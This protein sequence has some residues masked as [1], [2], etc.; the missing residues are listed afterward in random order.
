MRRFGKTVWFRWTAPA[1]GDAV[2]AANST[3]P[4]TVLA[5]YPAGSTNAI[6]CS[7]D[8]PNSGTSS[9]LPVRVQGGQTYDIQ[10]GGYGAGQSADFGS[11]NLAVEFTP[12]N[13]ADGDGSSP[14]ADC[15]DNNA[16]IHPGAPD[17]RNGVDDDCDGVIDPD[18]DGDGYTRPSDCNDDNPRIHPGATDIRGNRV[19]EDCAGKPAPFR[20]IKA[21]LDPAGGH[22]GSLTILTSL[23][24][25]N[26]PKG[27]KVNLRCYGPGA[28][29]RPTCGTQARRAAA[30]AGVVG[31]A[32]R[33][34]PLRGFRR[35]LAP[36]SVIEVRATKRGYI[37]FFQKVTMRASGAP[38]RS[39]PKCT[40][41][42]S[43]KLRTKCSGTR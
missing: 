7:D 16:S 19:N 43:R 15:N 36:G 1:L 10:V 26:V 20:R 2:F 4:D 35:V 29:G 34:L 11:F 14:P 5:A 6:D 8:A 22:Q 27:A 41:P 31:R 25:Q 12:E 39:R 33:N 42:G 17:V 28:R 37:G 23:V 9:R 18:R 3:D 40:Y 30:R 13:D 24:L 38:V 21:S 32:A